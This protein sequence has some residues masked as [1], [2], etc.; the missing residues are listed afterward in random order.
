MRSLA[1]TLTLYLP[2]ALLAQVGEKD[3]TK[4]KDKAPVK[5][6][7]FWTIV[8]PDGAKCSVTMPA[9][10]K[11]LE[12]R[13]QG[14]TM[15]SMFL[16]AAED[17]KTAYMLAFND[18][19]AKP[20]DEEAVKKALRAGFEKAKDSMKG[21]NENTQEITLKGNHPGLAFKFDVPELGQY[22][23]RI[24]LVNQRLYQVVV[25]GPKEWTEGEDV[26]RFLDSFQLKEPA[27]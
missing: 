3:K 14:D 4:D 13:K 21:A 10:P 12:P 22:R 17:G 18:L 7:E 19:P 5:E 20:A 15:I 27:K 2:L 8:T 11:T 6:K 16:L 1:A 24:Y 9:K 25:M 26:K 23:A